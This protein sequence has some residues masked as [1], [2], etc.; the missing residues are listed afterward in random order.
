MND[1]P[2]TE[3]QEYNDI[4]INVSNKGMTEIPLYSSSSSTRQVNTDYINLGDNESGYSMHNDDS[5]ISHNSKT[6]VSTI[7][8]YWNYFSNIAYSIK[9]KI[10]STDVGNKVI[11]VSGKAL[12]YVIYA[13]T[14]VY[15]KGVEGFS[16]LKQKIEKTNSSSNHDVDS[17]DNGG[18]ALIDKSNVM[19]I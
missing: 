14:K 4:S 8:S 12:E 17:L 19:D 16:Y 18:E 13:G 6:Y 5:N 7:S 11:N 15:E 3:Y 2:L 10:A 9:E 1:I